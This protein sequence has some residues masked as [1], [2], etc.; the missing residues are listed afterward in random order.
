MR[1]TAWCLRWG[2]GPCAGG[3]P[4][5]GFCGPVRAAWGACALRLCPPPA[6]STALGLGTG[7]LRGRG[8]G[9]GDGARAVAS[10]ALPAPGNLLESAFPSVLNWFVRLFKETVL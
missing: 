3:A 9:R 6:D 1:G 2:D 4:C 5:S 8:S 10:R 7:Q